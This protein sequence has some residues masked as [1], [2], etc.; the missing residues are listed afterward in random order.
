M[1]LI[2]EL[3]GAAFWAIVYVI[4]IVKGFKDKTYGMPIPAFCLNFSWEIIFSFIYPSYSYY[5]LI[6]IVWLLLDLLIFYQILKY[7]KNEFKKIR[8]IYFYLYFF[9]ILF[10]A[11]ALV[12][13]SLKQFGMTFANYYAPF[14]ISLFMSYLFIAM[15][16]VRNS[17]RGQSIYI[18]LFKMIGTV[19][20]SVWCFLY[21]DEL[22]GSKLMYFLYLSAFFLDLIYVVL[23]YLKS[24]NKLQIFIPAA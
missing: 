6:N 11:F 18:A 13:L 8:P 16:Y 15:Y 24:K 22:K 14:F 1:E 9:T 4:I 10:S 23:L 5:V 21:I 3:T 19:F 20:Y 12:F 7:G 17:L 2:L